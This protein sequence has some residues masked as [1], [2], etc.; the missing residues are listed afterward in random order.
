MDAA[1]IHVKIYGKSV[2]K[3]FCVFFQR[4]LVFLTQENLFKL[5]CRFLVCILHVLFFISI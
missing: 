2:K 1:N 4:F 3:Y 5:L